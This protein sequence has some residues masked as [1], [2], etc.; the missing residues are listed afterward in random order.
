MGTEF[1]DGLGRQIRGKEPPSMG[2]LR[3]K[4]NLGKRPSQNIMTFLILLL[5]LFAEPPELFAQ[6]LFNVDFQK[7][8]P[9]KSP[10]GWSSQEPEKM[11]RV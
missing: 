5:L 2:P 6:T 8:E 3:L 1:Q 4:F 10:S 9:G 11:A 7:D